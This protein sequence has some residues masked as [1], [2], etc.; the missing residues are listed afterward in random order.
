[1][2]STEYRPIGVF[3][4]G[5]GGLSILQEIR[6]ELPDEDI[7]YFADSAHCPYG[8][9]SEQEIRDLTTHAVTFMTEKRCKLIAI[10][11]NTASATSLAYLRNTFSLPIVGLEPALK[12][13]TQLTRNKRVGVLATE[14]TLK[15]EPLRRL[16]EQ[17]GAGIVLVTAPC[18]GLVELVEAGVTEGCAV[19]ELLAE[20]LAPMNEAK[21]DTLVLGCTHYPFVGQAIAK[22]LPANVRVVDSGEAVARQVR[23]VLERAGDRKAGSLPAQLQAFTTGEPTA[24]AKQLSRLLGYRMPVRGVICHEGTWAESPREA[25]T[26][27]PPVTPET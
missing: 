24:F 9:R 11:C 21:I 19:D 20:C 26:D 4:S 5:V 8:A 7:L 12:P 6:R 25:A 16:R 10:A 14:V 13:A 27:S 15:A 2:L 18:P 1:M 23:H 22:L 3:D 17:Y